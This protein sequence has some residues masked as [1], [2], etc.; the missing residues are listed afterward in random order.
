MPF[1]RTKGFPEGGFT[2]IEVLMAVA[3]IGIIVPVALKFFAVQWTNAQVIKNKM[4]AHY[5]AM[6][7][8][9]TI[10]DAIR[11]AEYVDWSLR[12]KWILTVTPSGELYSDQYYLDDK[13]YD[14]VKDLYRYHLG[15]HN[16]VVS[17]VVDWNCTKGENGLWMISIQGQVGQEIVFWQGKIK[18]RDSWN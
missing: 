11:E 4:E 1:P 5:A 3:I 15:A 9:K 6:L 10:S 7:A 2:L 8:G 13:D 17:G 16:P 18:A 12:G 14:G